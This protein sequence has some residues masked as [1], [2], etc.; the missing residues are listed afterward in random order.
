MNVSGQCHSRLRNIND[1][2]SIEDCGPHNRS[3]PFTDEKN[4]FSL[5]GFE[6]R[7]NQPLVVYN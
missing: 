3:G 5:S 2:N 4:V 6:H 7:T 1:T